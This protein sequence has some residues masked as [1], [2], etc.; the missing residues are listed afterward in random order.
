MMTDDGLLRAR[1]RLAD[2][3][4]AKVFFAVRHVL[5]YAAVN[6]R[7]GMPGQLPGAAR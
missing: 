3:K 5:D 1:C 7:P 2:L 4:M 6:S